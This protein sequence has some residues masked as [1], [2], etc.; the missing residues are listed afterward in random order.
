M[1][2]HKAALTA[3]AGSSSTSRS[4]PSPTE[5]FNEYMPVITAAL[6]ELTTAANG[7]PT[8]KSDINFHRTMD[9]QFAKDLDN[10]SSRV[11]QMTERLLSM[12]DAGQRE[13][14][15][16]GKDKVDFRAAPK[17]A[18]KPRRK[19]EE[20]E[21]VIDGYKRGVLGVVD[22]LLEDSVSASLCVNGIHD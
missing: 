2:D 21:D 7:L 12:V 16:K 14:K 15:G 11:L 8:T 4:V 20:E 9:R 13:M 3:K 18:E 19:L 6:D 22:G 5:G 10:A 17:A 1:A